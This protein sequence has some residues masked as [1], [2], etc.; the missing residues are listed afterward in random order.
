[1]TT[2]AKQIEAMMKKKSSAHKF[3]GGLIF[4][5]FGLL[6]IAHLVQYD[7]A[8]LKYIP[9][10]VLVWMAAVGSTICGFYMLFWS[11]TKRKLVL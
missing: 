10:K 2:S 5:I 9:E 8:I 6:L 3:W 7:L 11:I 1:M 4:F